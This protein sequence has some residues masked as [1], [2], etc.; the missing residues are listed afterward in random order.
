MCTPPLLKCLHVLQCCKIVFNT[1][2]ILPKTLLPT[3]QFHT[4]F[5]PSKHSLQTYLRVQCSPNGLPSQSLCPCICSVPLHQSIPST[6]NGFSSS[7][8]SWAPP[9]LTRRQ[10]QLVL[11]LCHY[12][13]RIDLYY[14][15]SDLYSGFLFNCTNTWNRYDT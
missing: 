10:N 8:T 15:T 7:I 1:W 13:I 5:F 6:L 2:V 11:P 9:Y 4:P 3:H 12:W 14:R